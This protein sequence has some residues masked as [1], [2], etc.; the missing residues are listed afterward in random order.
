MRSFV[1]K[2]S[3]M[4]TVTFALFLAAAG[5][6]ATEPKETMCAKQ[7]DGTYKCMASGKIEKVPCCETPTNGPKQRPKPKK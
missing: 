6:F 1:C 3:A 5:A 4:K 2:S 7:K